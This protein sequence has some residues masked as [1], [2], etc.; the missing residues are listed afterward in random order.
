MKA[1][2]ESQRETQLCEREREP[3]AKPTKLKQVENDGGQI[4]KLDPKSLLSGSTIRISRQRWVGAA[5]SAF[6]PE[7]QIWW[8]TLPMVGQVQI[9]AEHGD[10]ER[11]GCLSSLSYY[12]IGAVL[13]QQHGEDT[14][15]SASEQYTSLPLLLSTTYTCYTKA[16]V[17]Y[18]DHRI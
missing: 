17:T 6:G 3:E 8:A 10:W 14:V 18:G 15:L 13:T 4:C 11:S 2:A 5:I 16:N 1:L 9:S 12:A 7:V